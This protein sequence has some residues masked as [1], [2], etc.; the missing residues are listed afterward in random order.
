MDQEAQKVFDDTQRELK[1]LG[2]TPAGETKEEEVEPSKEEPTKPEEV[3]PKVEPEKEETEED[4]EPEAEKDK[5]F[6]RQPKQVPIKEY[7][8]LKKQLQAD[9]D[10]KLAK[11][12]EEMANTKPD[13]IKAEDLEADI[14]ALAQELDFDKEKVRKIVETARKGLVM[15]PEDRALLADMKTYK[16]EIE[17]RKESDLMKEQ[18]GIFNEEWR[19]VGLEKVYPNASDEQKAL[20]KAEMDKLAHSEKYHK[21]D[22][23]EI[24]QIK[25]ADFDKLLFSPKQKTF[26]SSRASITDE[27]DNGEI[28]KFDPSWTPAQVEQWEKKRQQHLDDNED[29]IQV[30]G[31]DGQ[32]WTE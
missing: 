9:F 4:E 8:E 29:K 3:E 20:A 24:L 26:E 2:L 16:A 30:R 5:T 6:E 15:S 18:E 25:K 31:A 19:N 17:A 28:G 10:E 7:K 32:E 21:L 11:M 13:E 27:G 23:A 14:T 1:E 12:R 22:L